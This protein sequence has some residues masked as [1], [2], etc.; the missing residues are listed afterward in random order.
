MG[1]CGSILVYSKDQMC[2]RD[3]LY[4]N[5]TILEKLNPRSEHIQNNQ[6]NTSLHGTLHQNTPINLTDILHQCGDISNLNEGNFI[7]IF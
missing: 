4:T 6:I 2:I 5:L 1:C 7:V 3:R